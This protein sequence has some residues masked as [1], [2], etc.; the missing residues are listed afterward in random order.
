MDYL[1]QQT[2]IR[3]C[4]RLGNLEMEICRCFGWGMKNKWC[5]CP[6][7]LMVIRFKDSLE[8]L[9]DDF[10]NSGLQHNR[11]RPM[12]GKLCVWLSFGSRDI[13]THGSNFTCYL[14]HYS[15]WESWD[16]SHLA[17]SCTINANARRIKWLLDDQWWTL[18]VKQ[19]TIRSLS[20]RLSQVMISGVFF[21]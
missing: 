4:Q 20:E 18:S 9:V 14:L 10:C 16:A 11:M 7:F 12:W 5:F 15:Q 21:V 3:F 6:R 17:T 13:F 2:N 19:V 8:L 1:E